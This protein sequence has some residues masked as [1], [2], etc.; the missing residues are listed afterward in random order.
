[1][2]LPKFQP[3][4][5]PEGTYRMEIHDWPEIRTNERGEVYVIFKFM[6]YLGNGDKQV[7][8]HVIPPWQDRY[9]DVL[10]L[11]GAKKD[12]N[13]DFILDS[14]SIGAQFMADVILVEDKKDPTKKYIKIINFHSLE[15]KDMF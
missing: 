14:V 12:T 4:T 3:R 1:M 13:G 2:R 5:I 8:G 7:I 15:E 9:N 10:N 6:V 11:A